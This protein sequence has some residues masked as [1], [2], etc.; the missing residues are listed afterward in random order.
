MNPKRQKKTAKPRPFVGLTYKYIEQ[1]AGMGMKL[2]SVPFT[3]DRANLRYEVKTKDPKFILWSLIAFV[4]ITLELGQMLWEL[5]RAKMDP[6]MTRGEWCLVA[7]LFFSWLFMTGIH[8]NVLL[9]PY[10][11]VNHLNQ[12]I[13]LRRW[14]GEERLPRT[15]D[16]K[17]VRTQMW[18]CSFQCIFQALMITMERE[19][20]QFLYSYLPE[21]YRNMGTTA[22]WMAYAYY[23]VSTNFMAGLTQYF[24]SILNVQTCNQVLDIR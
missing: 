6:D 18:F 21:N 23:R 8:L 19:K 16:H 7:F 1:C 22:I 2:N 5:I 24:M 14:F 9:H 11:L 4:V 13:R 12:L 17:V 3:Y 10:E 15:S 20:S